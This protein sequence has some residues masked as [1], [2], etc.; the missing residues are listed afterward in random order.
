MRTYDKIHFP[1][2]EDLE[3][4]DKAIVELYF[5]LKQELIK[6]EA[7]YEHSLIKKYAVFV[8]KTMSVHGIKNE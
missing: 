6:S 2:D 8:E 5:A 1:S 3:S 4:R 7:G